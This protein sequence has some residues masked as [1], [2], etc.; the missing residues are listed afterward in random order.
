MSC[1]SAFNRLSFYKRTFC[2]K[3]S[4]SGSLQLLINK[5]GGYFKLNHGKWS[6]NCCDITDWWGYYRKGLGEVEVHIGWARQCLTV[7]SVVCGVW[8]VVSETEGKSLIALYLKPRWEVVTPF[9][10]WKTPL[11]HL[12]YVISLIYIISALFHL[13]AAVKRWR[14]L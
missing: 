4:Y 13:L 14:N 5:Q 3:I 7:V 9:P 8:C 12:N 10:V 2:R 1:L 11:H 6:H